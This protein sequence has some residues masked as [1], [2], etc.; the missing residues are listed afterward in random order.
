MEKL[1]SLIVDGFGINCAAEMKAAY[2]SVGV[3]AEIMHLSELFSEKVD[4]LDF[5][6]LNFPGGFSYGDDIGAG[7]A[8]ASLLKYKRLASGKTFFSILLRYI[9]K[10]GYIIGIC[11]GFQILLALGLLPGLNNDYEQEAALVVNDS[12][13]F[14]NRWVSCKVP[15]GSLAT[16][17]LPEGISDYPVRHKEG[18][19][20][21]KNAEIAKQ[22]EKNGLIAL[23][24][25][26]ANGELASD[27]P[28]N[29]NNS[30]MHTAGLIHPKGRIIGMMPHPE[31]ALSHY[32]HPNWSG[33][34]YHSNKF[35][36]KGDGFW[37]FK[38]IVDVVRQGKEVENVCMQ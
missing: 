18:R 1:R 11:N 14:E 17:L 6:I 28:A 21:V 25:C 26:L 4:L 12:G 13:K 32:H 20:V 7:R 16:T 23:Q 15:D 27:Y 9:E 34:T 22:I 10:G 5:D 24:Y 36:D 29:P 30:W 33:N 3:S 2:K 35:S 8:L 19:L 37:F 38:K 31:A